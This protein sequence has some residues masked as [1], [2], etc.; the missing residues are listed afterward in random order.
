MI[1]SF[2]KG[3]KACLSF[4]WAG[5]CAGYGFSIFKGLEL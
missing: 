5:A 4:G 3:K 1:F 2:L